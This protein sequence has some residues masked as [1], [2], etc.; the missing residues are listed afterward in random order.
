MPKK[1][2][3]PTIGQPTESLRI[4]LA[5]SQNS[6]ANS[7]TP[8]SFYGEGRDFKDVVR[9]IILRDLLD[10]S[11]ELPTRIFTMLGSECSD[12]F[13]WLQNG[14]N[15]DYC[16]SVEM[17]ENEF[18]IQKK[19]IKNK[20]GKFSK[21]VHP[22]HCTVRQYFSGTHMPD[23]K[24]PKKDKELFE[25]FF[26]LIFLDYI[27]CYNKSMI[28]DIRTLCTNK[29]RL[30]RIIAERGSVR[31]YTTTSNRFQNPDDR[32]MLHELEAVYSPLSPEIDVSS[33]TSKEGHPLYN[34]HLDA[35]GTHYSISE[36][37]QEIG[38]RCEQVHCLYY[39]DG[40]KGT[41]MLLSG[42]KLTKIEGYELSGPKRIVNCDLLPPLAPVYLG[43]RNR[44]NHPQSREWVAKMKENGV[45]NFRDDEYNQIDKSHKKLKV[46][47]PK[48][49]KKVD[50]LLRRLGKKDPTL[51]EVSS[52]DTRGIIT[53]PMDKECR[54]ALIEAGKID[55]PKANNREEWGKMAVAI[56]NCLQ[57]H[58]RP[59][60]QSTLVKAVL[61]AYPEYHEL[62]TIQAGKLNQSKL[63]NAMAWVKAALKEGGYTTSKKDCIAGEILKLT[64]KG[65]K[66]N[67]NRAYKNSWSEHFMLIK[68]GQL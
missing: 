32:Q 37:F 14:L 33:E 2:Y 57:S 17:F 26:D 9:F 63:T 52:N 23:N 58:K 28:W 16:A 47:N 68:K 66:T 55:K 19:N 20:F 54:L 29:E 11:H 41:R 34:D 7:H 50:A 24:K 18:N 38:I 12:L 35:Y 59:V 61:D 22:Y 1:K 56:T 42:W 5:K 49:F 60:C 25:N 30:H 53:Q 67:L 40:N 31:L 10:R 62:Q 21:H 39:R 46:T 15:I 48:T 8:V 4:L 13:L 45:I 65:R 36:I 64:D 3:L 51:L 6:I 43:L 44:K 27:S